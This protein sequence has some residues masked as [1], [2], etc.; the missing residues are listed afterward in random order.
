VGLEKMAE[1]NVMYKLLQLVKVDLVPAMPR[2]QH[3]R[4]DHEYLHPQWISAGYPNSPS[5][6]VLVVEVLVG[7]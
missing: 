7:E 6:Y 5:Y 4:E 3:L 2:L 1:E